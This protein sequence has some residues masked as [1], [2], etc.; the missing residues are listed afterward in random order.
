MVRY[1]R[2]AALAWAVAWMLLLLLWPRAVPSDEH[3]HARALLLLLAIC[4]AFG[5]FL[6]LRTRP[7][8]DVLHPAVALVV[9][10]AATA[11][12]FL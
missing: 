11:L 7:W 4:L 12:A 5:S 10:A 8:R 3:Q 6:G 9:L 1:A 2:A